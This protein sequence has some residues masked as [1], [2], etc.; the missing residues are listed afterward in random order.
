MKRFRK[1]HYLMGLA[2]L[3]LFYILLLAGIQYIIA[4][5]SRPRTM[6][7]M[8]IDR[9]D[10]KAHPENYPFTHHNRAKHKFAELKLTGNAEED[11]ITLKYAAMEI[12]RTRQLKD[13][14]HGIHFT[15]GENSRYGTYV[16]MLNMLNIEKADCYGGLDNDM[17][18]CPVLPA[19]KDV[20]GPEILPPL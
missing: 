6:P 18:V 1:L 12:R 8:L 17:W 2:S 20:T 3:C 7:I 13:V 16:K 15:I 19:R 5:P 10:V 9:D 14:I 11:D 4:H